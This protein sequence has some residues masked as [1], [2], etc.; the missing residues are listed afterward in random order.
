MQ[1][2]AKYGRE[3][4]FAAALVYARVAEQQVHEPPARVQVTGGRPHHR[5]ISRSYP[6]Y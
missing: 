2:I 4:A 3:I 5:Q 6:S 1:Q